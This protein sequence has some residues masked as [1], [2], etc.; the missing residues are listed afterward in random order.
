V[1]VREPKPKQRKS[2]KNENRYLAP[3]PLQIEWIGKGAAPEVRLKMLHVLG[4]C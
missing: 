1:V 4:F 2:Y 3:N